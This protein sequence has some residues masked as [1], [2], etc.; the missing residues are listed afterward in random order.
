MEKGENALTFN[1]LKDTDLNKVEDF[2]S[3]V[4]QRDIKTFQEYDEITSIFAKQ[5]ADLNLSKEEKQKLSFY[6]KFY[7]GNAYDRIN[8][9]LRDNWNYE[10]QGIKTKEMEEKYQEFLNEIKAIFSLCPANNLNFVTFRKVPLEVFQS[11]GIND[12]NELKFLKDKFY[13]DP[14]FVST[15]LLN[16]WHLLDGIEMQIIIPLECEEAFPLIGSNL[17]FHTGEAEYL[18]ENESLFKVY[19]VEDIDSKIILKMIYIP[20]KIWQQKL[21]VKV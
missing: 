2:I 18:I 9:L 12:K 3:D 1:V 14:G 5:Y 16:S 7:T 17:S 13:F 21:I 6:L 8:A 10:H 4:K 20:K 19:D 15:S 11:Y